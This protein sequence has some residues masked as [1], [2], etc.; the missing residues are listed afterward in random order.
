M[1]ISDLELLLVEVP[2]MAP[3]PPMRSLVV[4]LATDAGIEGWGEGQVAWRPAELFA[5]RGALLP[6]LSGRSVFQL[7]EL[8][9]HEALAPGGLRSAIEIAAADAL[10]KICRQPLCHLWGG[11]YRPRIPLAARL[12]AEPAERVPHRARELAEQGFHTQILAATGSVADDLAA[13]AA[14]RDAGGERL[15][16]RLDLAGQFDFDQA[17]HL[18]LSLPRGALQYLLDPLAE[19]SPEALARLRHQTNAPLAAAR[20]ITAPRDV[21]DLARAAAVAHV[22]VDLDQV[23]GPSAARKCAHVA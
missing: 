15:E 22:V 5:R 10:G 12:R 16:L 2:C 21:F 7:E 9:A 17:R 13:V 3:S 19:S 20:A 8:S 14:L 18:A 4:R 6:I 23:G 11:Q 1:R